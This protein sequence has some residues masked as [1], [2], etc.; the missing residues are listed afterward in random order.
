MILKS[1]FIIVALTLAVFAIPGTANNFSFVGNFS[2]DNSIQLFNFSLIVDDT[3]TVQ[4]LSYGGSAD[5]PG[6]TNAAGQ[7]ILAG[8]FE[9]LLQ[10]YSRDSGVA[11]TSPLFPSFSACGPNTPDPNRVPACYDVFAQAFLVAGDYILALAQNPNV[12]LG[13]FSD[14]FQ[15]D[16]D[17]DFNGNFQG[18]FGPPN[19]GDSHWAVDILSVGAASEVPEPSSTALAAIAIVLAGIGAR[20]TRARA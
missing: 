13:N 11:V 8:G 14:G 5:N 10:V 3:I 20:R 16:G 9:P 12:P 4:T 17:P 1:R 15:Y 2:H 6:G 19:Q 18:S 7:V